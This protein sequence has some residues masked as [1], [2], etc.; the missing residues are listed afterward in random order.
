M[1]SFFWTIAQNFEI[2]KNDIF[3]CKVLWMVVTGEWSS[4]GFFVL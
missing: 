4:V 1:F 2:F 3:D